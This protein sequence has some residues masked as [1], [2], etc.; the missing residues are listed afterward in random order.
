MIQR[1]SVPL[2]VTPL[3]WGMTFLIHTPCSLAGN[4][5]STTANAA[6][7]QTVDQPEHSAILNAIPD[8]VKGD[9]ETAV[10]QE[11]VPAQPSASPVLKADQQGQNSSPDPT[12]MPVS[13][14]TAPAA[15]T[16]P[17]QQLTKPNPQSTNSTIEINTANSLP[18]LPIST[19]SS[20][21]QPTDSRSI[22][23]KLE[24]T[25]AQSPN[26][27]V[28]GQNSQAQ[29]GKTQPEKWH[30]EFKPYL[31][32]PFSISG[33]SNVKNFSRNF[34]LS[35]NEIR[36]GLRNTLDFAFLGALEA[37]TPNYNIG[38]L[39]NVD[40][41]ALSR[42]NTFTRPVRLPGLADFIP[43]EVKS[44]FNTQIWTVDLAGS[45]R[46][47]N[48]SKVNPAGVSSEFD[49]GPF[50][51]DAIGGVNLTGVSAELDVSTDL[52]GE[53]SFDRGRT[54]ASPLLGARFRWN[55]SSKLA[56]L[57]LASVSGFGIGGL[58]RY[59]VQGGVDWRFYRNISLG[60]GYRFSYLDYSGDS[61]DFNL[62]VNQNG[63]YLNFSFRF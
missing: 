17:D 57:G 52:G 53:G 34:D 51:I 55:A 41:L 28:S 33:S 14:I 4:Q 2:C 62:R 10:S 25:L 47:Y 45:Y 35:P 40:Y 3:L 7:S 9:Q 1:L 11:L 19:S 22:S 42:T 54:I 24:G 39:A 21:L 30:F 56:L 49:L 6:E 8:Q 26:P 5:P 50:V 15:K 32:L 31:Y 13:A 58:T 59:G 60:L 48:R 36:T 16:H 18:D 43:T 44:S 23:G 38:I 37:W 27:E 63:P 12:A 29:S 61:N 46:F 20:D